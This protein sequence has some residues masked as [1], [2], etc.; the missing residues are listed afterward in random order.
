MA[1]TDSLSRFSATI[2][3]TLRTRLELLS[4]ETEESFARYT[5]HLLL[6]LIILFFAG[7]A[8]L[9]GVLLVLAA[10]WDSHRHLAITSMMLGFFL[11][12]GGLFWYLK[13]SIAQQPGFLAHTIAELENDLEALRQRDN[14]FDTKPDTESDTEQD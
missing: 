1:I 9:L 11:L 7:I 13:A 10:F 2:I 3:A 8:I 5:R 6:A 12:A 14:Q 4:V